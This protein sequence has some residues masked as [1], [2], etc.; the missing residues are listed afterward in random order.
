MHL[1]IA[2]PI[3]FHDGVVSWL[4]AHVWF[5]DFV[6]AMPPKGTPAKAGGPR[7]FNVRIVSKTRDRQQAQVSRLAASMARNASDPFSPAP[8]D[9][10][11]LDKLLEQVRLAEDDRRLRQPSTVGPQRPECK[12]RLVAR[13]KIAWPYI[14]HYAV[15]N[16][17]TFF[18]ETTNVSTRELHDWS[19]EGFRVRYE[20]SLWGWC[21][22]VLQGGRGWLTGSNVVRA[23]VGW[24]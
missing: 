3:C 15:V 18:K 19:D 9:L 8:E 6:A 7:E 21:C 10:G 1:W 2:L 20:L 24:V 22:M 12:L 17:L 16:A 14:L 11:A 13:L 23:W 4:L 5:A